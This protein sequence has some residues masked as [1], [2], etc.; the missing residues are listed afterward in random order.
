MEAVNAYIT[1]NNKIKHTFAIHRLLHPPSCKHLQCSSKLFKQ[2]FQAL[3]LLHKALHSGRRYMTFC[4][5]EQL[6]RIAEWLNAALGSV[7]VSFASH[8]TQTSIQH[9]D[10]L[11]VIHFSKLQAVTFL[12]CYSRFLYRWSPS[13]CGCSNVILFSVFLSIEKSSVITVWC[14]Y[15]D[16]IIVLDIGISGLG[17]LHLCEL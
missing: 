6:N 12:F 9:A 5:S 17:F 13:I 8:V 16:F 11:A 4:C 15:T 7:H 2:T 1:Q 3:Y 10:A 14:C